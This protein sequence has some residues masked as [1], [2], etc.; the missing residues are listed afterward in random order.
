MQ[1]DG[2]KH[3]PRLDDRWRRRPSRSSAERRWQPMRRSIASRRAPA[4]AS[5][6]RRG[7][8]SRPGRSAGRSSASRAGR[9]GG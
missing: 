5:A 8:R 1:R 7:G 3:G 6:S 9:R 2:T 4:R